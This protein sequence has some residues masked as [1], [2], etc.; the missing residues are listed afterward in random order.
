M[1]R[2]VLKV[3]LTLFLFVGVMQAQTVIELTK[4]GELKEKLGSDVITD[5][6]VKGPM[7][8][9]DFQDLITAQRKNIEKLDLSAVVLSGDTLPNKAIAGYT[10]LTTLVLPKGVA[11]LN[12]QAIFECPELI[13][14]ALSEENKH[15]VVKENVLYTINQD[16]LLVCPG[17]K[18]GEFI[19]P[20]TVNAI[21]EY[22][23]YANQK[24]TSVKLP[25]SVK[26]IKGN[27]FA[28]MD[29]LES[30]NLENVEILGVQAFSGSPLKNVVLTN[31]QTIFRG[32]FEAC[33]DLETITLGENVTQIGRRFILKYINDRSSLKS[34]TCLAAIPPRIIGYLGNSAYCDDGVLYVP[35]GSL[36]AYQT[37]S[38]W[39]EVKDIREIEPTSNETIASEGNRV[40]AIQGGIRVDA[41]SPVSVSVYAANGMLVKQQQVAGSEEISLAKGLYYVVIEKNK[42]VALK[43]K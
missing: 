18:A 11:Y 3:L 24:I 17:G 43:V 39:S 27:A 29:L 4:A 23:F 6:S 16:T 37:A 38:G 41:Q 34:I 40:A 7:G 22:A 21:G 28:L 36:A 33:E 14:I 20:E 35:K 13:S 30:I 19:V 32:A 2:K 31:V 1:F 42:A 25:E 12:S 15:F 8:K 26:E 9:A 10:K 5:L